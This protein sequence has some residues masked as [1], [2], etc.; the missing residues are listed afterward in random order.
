VRADED[1]GVFEGSAIQNAIYIAGQAEWPISPEE[2][3]SR[4]R[5]VL[6]AGAFGYIA[7]G[8]GGESTM[9]AN[10]EAFERRRIRPR[11]LTGNVQRDVSVEV[12]GTPSA[13]PFF[14]A[15]VGVLSIAHAEGELA[16]ARAAA[17][18]GIPFVLSSAASHSIEE[19][20]ETMGGAPRWFQ[21]Y[22]VND[23]DI[24]AIFVARAETAGFSA[25]V[26]TLDTSILGWRP[27]DLANAYLPFIRGEGC[28]QFFTDP[29]F[30]AKLDK[31]PE[32]DLLTAAA[33]M[34]MTFPNLALTWD[35]LDW[36]RGRTG[37]P[38]LVKG[39]LTAEDARRARGHGVDGIIVSNHGGR[40]VDGAVAA[41]DALVEVRG[42]VGD[43]Y[44][45]LMDS[46]IRRGADVLKAL[47]LGA[48]AVL[49]GRPYVYGLAVGGQAGVE[50]V[51]RQLLA[52]TDLTLALA[53][54]NSVRELDADFL[55]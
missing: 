19:I 12:L 5:D 23:R 55:A 38:L 34:L 17:A 6:D 1:R 36:L 47:A 48:D 8:A 24:A 15:P 7:G 22:W 32:E 21:L 45:L 20:A 54:R 28:A 14:L 27:R 3:E 50:A 31:P 25:I 35:D 42:E 16:A 37:L 40:Q 33:T 13:A 53:G 46:G 49:L 9:R 39:V 18:S 30:C 10:L 26:V 29:V 43:E 44:P 2:W 41:L 11:M 52:E 51:V 4:A